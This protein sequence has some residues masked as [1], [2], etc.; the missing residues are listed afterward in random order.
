MLI[1][2]QRRSSSDSIG[3]ASTRNIVPVL[4]RPTR[5]LDEMEGFAN[6]TWDKLESE[7]KGSDGLGL[8]SGKFGW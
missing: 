7:E 6:T 5:V 1:F 2:S 3:Y 4:D 8:R